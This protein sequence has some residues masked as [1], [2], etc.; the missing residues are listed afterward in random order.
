MRPP[1]NHNG[2]VS[3]THRFVDMA[4]DFPKRQDAAPHTEAVRSR[5]GETSREIGRTDPV[6]FTRCCHGQDELYR[7]QGA[8]PPSVSPP[9]KS[10]AWT[11]PRL[12]GAR[13]PVAPRRHADPVDSS[14]SPTPTPASTPRT[15]S[16]SRREGTLSRYD[17]AVYKSGGS[18][19][20]LLKIS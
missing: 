13:V 14:L 8:R 7:L 3:P 15:M 5:V 12:L 4:P 18:S 19:P 6:V 17:V 2:R 1:Q 16:R 9:A 10:S 20:R 11:T